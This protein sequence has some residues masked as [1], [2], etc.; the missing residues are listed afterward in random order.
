LEFEVG[1][2]S[3]EIINL[4]RSVRKFIPGKTL[5]KNEIEML[6]RAAM[7][8]PSAHNG[9][10]WVFV[11][12]DDRTI[13][14]KYADAMMYSKML[15]EASCAIVIAADKNRVKS[16]LYTQDLSAAM[17]NLLLEAVHLGLGG[18]W[19]GVFPRVERM[20]KIKELLNLPENIEPFGIAAIGYPAEENANHFI[21]RFQEDRIHY[22]EW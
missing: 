14:T 17:Q 1:E 16:P 4:R 21:D 9:Q 15:H 10:P 22:N 8:A 5:T 12:I 7:Q 11:V 3:M 19:L 13:M 18:C 6:L 20:M 2:I